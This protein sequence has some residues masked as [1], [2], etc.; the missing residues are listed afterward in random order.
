MALGV[1]AHMAKRA[2]VRGGDFTSLFV[3]GVAGLWLQ[4]GEKINPRLTATSNAT[5]VGL[6]AT[7]ILFPPRGRSAD[8]ASHM[9]STDFECGEFFCQSKS[10]Y[11]SMVYPALTEASCV[12]RTPFSRVRFSLRL[13]T[14]L[15]IDQWSCICA[16]AMIDT[17]WSI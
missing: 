2:K 14:A 4:S 8:L 7:R 13:V 3:H 11:P 10:M 16:P 6:R 17:F 15:F 12:M 5:P 1:Q 9:P